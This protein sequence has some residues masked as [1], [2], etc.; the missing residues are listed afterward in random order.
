[1]SVS[2][3]KTSAAPKQSKGPMTALRALLLVPE[4][5]FDILPPVKPMNTLIY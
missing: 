2:S 3:M 1:M 4:I 5:R